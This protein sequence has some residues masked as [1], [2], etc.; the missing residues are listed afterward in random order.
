MKSSFN[1][2]LIGPTAELVL[3]S[4]DSGRRSEVVINEISEAV[5]EVDL[6]GLFGKAEG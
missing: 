3:E 2:W 5:D 6:E 4:K 1:G